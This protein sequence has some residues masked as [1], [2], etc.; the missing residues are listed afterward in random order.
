MQTFQHSDCRDLQPGSIFLA[1]IKGDSNFVA[2]RGWI[3][4]PYTP[5]RHTYFLGV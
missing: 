1:G 5:V 3:S 2:K 4:Y